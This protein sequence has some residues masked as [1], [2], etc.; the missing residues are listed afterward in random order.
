MKDRVKKR[1][2]T[3]LIGIFVTFIVTKIVDYLFKTDSIS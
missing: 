3:W 1:L 2:A